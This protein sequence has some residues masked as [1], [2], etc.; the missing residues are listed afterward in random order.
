VD[1]STGL[2]YTQAVNASI[3]GPRGY[4]YS[5]SIMP[6]GTKLSNLRF[7]TSADPY[8]VRLMSGQG[9][10]AAQR[11]VALPAGADQEEVFNIMPYSATTTTT[12]PAT[13]TTIPGTTTTLAGTG[14]LRVT[15]LRSNGNS[16]GTT[17]DIQLGTVKKSNSNNI[18]LFDGLLF[19]TYDLVVS[20]D[21]YDTYRGTYTVTGANTQIIYL[22]RH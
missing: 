7:S 14:S 4:T 3:S 22:T 16:L 17:A 8:I 9:F 1:L 13:T 21:K 5:G 18:V 12:L 15:V 6:G 20:A 2:N 11:N 10:D 19:V